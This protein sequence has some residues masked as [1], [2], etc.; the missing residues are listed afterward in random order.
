M[1]LCKAAVLN[2]NDG[3]LEKRGE[4]AGSPDGSKRVYFVLS[5]TLHELY[6]LSSGGKANV[7]C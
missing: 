3:G 6:T 1:C 5:V 2:W 4:V 7:R